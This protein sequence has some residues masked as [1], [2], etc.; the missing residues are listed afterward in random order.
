MRWALSLSMFLVCSSG[1]GEAG[2]SGLDPLVQRLDGLELRWV[3]GQ[4]EPGGGLSTRVEVEFDEPWDLCIREA[5]IEQMHSLGLWP[6]DAE[7]DLPLSTSRSRLQSRKVGD[8]IR[9]L[10]LA[11]PVNLP[12]PKDM[13]LSLSVYVCR[14][15]ESSGLT[16]N[17]SRFFLAPDPGVVPIWRTSF[18][19][20]N[21]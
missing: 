17:P 6:E 1:C 16:A 13:Q 9:Q 11:G 2:V 4:E 14:P 20:T 19:P 12:V 10:T 5:A 18:E 3:Y 8:G 15:V 7:T 21:D